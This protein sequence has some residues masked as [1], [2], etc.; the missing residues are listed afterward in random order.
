M[1]LCIYKYFF[2]VFSKCINVINV[3]DRFPDTEP[4]LHPGNILY[5]ALVQSFVCLLAVF[6]FVFNTLSDLVNIPFTSS[7]LYSHV[8]FPVNGLFFCCP[9]A[10]VVSRL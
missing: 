3:I 10:D 2:I 1:F 4:F 9:Y 6:G 7:Y 5:F 8:T